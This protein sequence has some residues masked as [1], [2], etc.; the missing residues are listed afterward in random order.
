VPRLSA[1]LPGVRLEVGRWGVLFE[2]ARPGASCGQCW[3]VPRGGAHGRAG[4]ANELG[5]EESC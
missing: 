1:C 3:G 5:R 4:R 2:L